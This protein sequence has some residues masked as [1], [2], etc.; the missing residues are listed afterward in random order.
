M[1]KNLC[2]YHCVNTPGSYKCICPSG[3]TLERNRQCQD[4]DECITREHNCRSD[5]VCVNL[6]GSYRCYHVNCPEGYDK[7]GNKYIVTKSCLLLYS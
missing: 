4:I 6:L 7:V 2:Q 5:D 3:F 1:I